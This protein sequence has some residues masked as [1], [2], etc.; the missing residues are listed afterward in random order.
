MTFPIASSDFLCPVRLLATSPDL[1]SYLDLWPSS[2][3]TF[4]THNL[5]LLVAAATPSEYSRNWANVSLSL[6]LLQISTSFFSIS[7]SIS[8]KKHIDE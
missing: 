1:S 6:P 2:L 5:S 7:I 3:N 4:L 8:I